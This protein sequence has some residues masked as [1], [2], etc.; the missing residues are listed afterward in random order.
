MTLTT[1]G[2]QTVTVT[3]TAN[4]SMT[5]TSAAI[6]VS[7]AGPTITVAPLGASGGSSVLVSGSHFVAKDTVKLYLDNTSSTAL[8][9]TTA[10][11]S[12]SI[13]KSIKIP[14]TAT[15]GAHSL[16][17]V[18]IKSGQASTPLAVTKVTITEVKATMIS[19][20]DSFQIATGG[21]ASGE[22][23]GFHKGS[24]SGPVLGYGSLGSTGGITLTGAELPSGRQTL[25]LVGRTSGY[26]ATGT[27]SVKPQIAPDP[28][29]GPSTGT[30]DV[31]GG[32]F[33]PNTMVTVLFG[34]T[35]VPCTGTGSVTVTTDA[36]GGFG[37]FTSVPPASITP[38]SGTKPS[39]RPYTI[40]ASAG[41]VY[42]KTGYT[43][44]S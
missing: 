37:V 28:T 24:A 7:A 31:D 3:D 5:G 18:G 10:T 11:T 12:G 13:S 36:N 15:V 25:V 2:N 14:T 34:C 32:G 19:Q 21:F 17:A 1:T 29:S 16:I 41:T 9:S 40:G 22:T 38:P 6:T 27:V 4:S 8:A 23:V 42:V 35:K 30:I 33:Q 20:I 39:S 43:V 26:Q 44:T